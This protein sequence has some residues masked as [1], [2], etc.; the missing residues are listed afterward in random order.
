MSISTSTSTNLSTAEAEARLVVEELIIKARKAMEEI[1]DYS[2]EQ[3]NTL[4]QAVAW[5][6]YQQDHAE[7]LAEIAVRDTGLGNVKDKVTKN[8]RKTFGT[9]RDL[10]DPEAKSVGIIKVDEAKGITEIAKPVGVVAAVAPS[11]NPGATPANV[12]MMG[13]KGRNAVIIAPS[14]KGASTTVKLLQYIHAELA[15]VGAPSDLVQS[16]PMPVSKEL[17]NELMKQADMVTVTGSAN[18]VRA[19]QTCGTPNAC[20]SAGNVVTIVDASANLQDAAHKIMLSKTFDNATSCSSDNSLVI[21]ASIYEQMIEA[22]QKEGGY[23]CTAT[24]K[25]QLQKAM[26]DEKGKRK[27]GTTAKDADVMA[28]EA[29]FTN[30]AAQQA[31]F[32]MVE[33]SGVGKGYPFS[34]EKLSLALTVYKV[35]NFEEALDLTKRI[36]NFVGRGHSCGLHTTNEEHI[37]RIGF[38]MEVCRLLINQV[39]CFGNGGSFDNGLNFTLSMGGGTWAGNNIK[40][41]LSYRHFIQTTK[42]SRLIPEVIPKEDEL[43]GSYWAKYG[44]N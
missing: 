20:V 30:P 21:E 36:L 44:R 1:K 16:L 35:Q 42:V 24:E 40:E 18:N 38:A 5:A 3:A 4:V 10:L 32:F 22:L 7:E 17:T 28:K 14:P 15:R 25:E 43:F 12:T 9:L 8:K 2:Q 33:E 37:Q 6:I 26:W 11:T 34:G 29:G 13:L 39:Q 31:A 41:N 27:G 19:G 23:M